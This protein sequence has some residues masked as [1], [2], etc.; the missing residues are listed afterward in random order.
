MSFFLSASGLFD[1]DLTFFLEA[2]L[3]ALFSLV[4]NFFFLSPLS[5]ELK[6]RSAYL[7][8][9]QKTAVFGLITAQENLCTSLAIFLEE[10]EESARQLALFKTYTTK[11]LEPLLP[12]FQASNLE[13]LNEAKGKVFNA[14][15]QSFSS[16]AFDVEE[17]TKN[18]FFSKFF[19]S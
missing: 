16:L 4:V 11:K 6:E 15:A 2:L 3:F 19:L 8:F 12:F 13:L 17:L 14:T 5:L 9:S 10:A 7:E 18:F 1:F